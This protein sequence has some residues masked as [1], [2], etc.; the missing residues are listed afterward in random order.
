MLQ[1]LPQDGV[2]DRQKFYMEFNFIVI[3]L[4]AEP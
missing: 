3:Q 2:Y 4:V 1:L